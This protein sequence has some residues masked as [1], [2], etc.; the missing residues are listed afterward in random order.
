ML[1]WTYIFTKLYFGL[2]QNCLTLFLSLPLLLFLPLSL[3][4]S[5]S[6]HVVFYLLLLHLLLLCRVNLYF[7]NCYTDLRAIQVL[8]V[9]PESKEQRATK[10]IEEEEAE[11][12]A[13]TS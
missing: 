11:W 8:R 2:V 3:S 1:L 12:Y 7:V 10:A 5:F 6:L 4:L 13:I 9:H